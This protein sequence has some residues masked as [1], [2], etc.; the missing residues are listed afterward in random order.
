MIINTGARTD[1]AQYYSEWLLRR[2]EEGYVFVRN[3]FYPH[4]V[5]NLTL[6]PAVVDC[7]EFCSKNYAPLLPQLHEVFD[8]YNTHFHFTITA[9]GPDI[10]PGVPSYADAVEIT[11]VY[12]RSGSAM[13]PSDMAMVVS[14]LVPAV[15]TDREG[16]RIMG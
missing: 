12:G 6:D 9:Y 4:Q 7:V 14:E 11:P 15:F 3:P 13:S 2:F 8:R 1:T 5:S 16:N 10:E